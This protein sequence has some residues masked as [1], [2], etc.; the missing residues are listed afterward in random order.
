MITYFIQSGEFVKIGKTSNMPQRL[1]SI[2]TSN[3][4]PLTVLKMSSMPE[5]VAHKIA[6]EL[7]ERAQG[8]WF[9]VNH[10]LIQWIDAIDP[11]ADNS[12]QQDWSL[13][14]FKVSASLHARISAAAFRANMSKPQFLRFQLTKIVE[15][16]EKLNAEGAAQ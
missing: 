2:A 7:T 12:A 5:L 13:F 10:Q 6:S 9:K 4:L 1:L 3:P 14:A 11:V 8:E 16:W 15:E